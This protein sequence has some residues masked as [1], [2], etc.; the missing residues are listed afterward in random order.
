VDAGLSVPDALAV[1][2]V[3]NSY[4]RGAS[5][6]LGDRAPRS[7]DLRGSGRTDEFPLLLGLLETP[8]GEA[9][10]EDLF[11]TGLARVL[12]GVAAALDD[13]AS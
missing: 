3:V 13:R 6:P 12:D 8:P 4:V 9:P 5:A 7:A 11:E 2:H 1:L 10:P